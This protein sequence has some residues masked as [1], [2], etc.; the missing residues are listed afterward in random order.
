M[1]IH[2]GFYWTHAERISHSVRDVA[3]DEARQ[4]ILLT[5]SSASW[6]DILETFKIGFGPHDDSVSMRTQHELRKRQAVGTSAAATFS[7][8]ISIPAPPSSSP[9]PEADTVTKALDIHY[10]DTPILPPDIPG[11]DGATLRGSEV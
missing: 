1:R 8:T 7:P 2:L 11:V 3:I 6:K 9:T 5:T 10:L 4:S